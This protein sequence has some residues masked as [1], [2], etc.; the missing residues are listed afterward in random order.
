MEEVNRFATEPQVVVNTAFSDELDVE[1]GEEIQLGWFVRTQD[2]IE[3][4]EENFTIHQIVAMSGQGQLAG[5]T[6][7]ALFTDLAT[8]QEWQ[9]SEG[10]VTSIRISLDG[11]TETR[12]A[13]NPVIDAVIETLNNSIGVDESGLQLISEQSA[14]TLASTNVLR[15][16]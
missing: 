8:A 12:S 2:G 14:V 5:T 4:I 7:P 10:N 11:E 1:E 6:A 13:M 9:Q 15:R 3:R 16:L